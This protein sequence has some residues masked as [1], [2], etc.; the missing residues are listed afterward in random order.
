VAEALSATAPVWQQRGGC[1]GGAAEAHS[2]TAAA[3]QQRRGCG[4]GNSAAAA[5]S[6]TA[7]GDGRGDG[8]GDGNRQSTR[9]TRGG[10]IERMER[11]NATISWARGTSSMIQ[12]LSIYVN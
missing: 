8:E 2:T 4:G 3:R 11:G 12:F 9:R 10:H 1:G 7:V 6:A 5:Q